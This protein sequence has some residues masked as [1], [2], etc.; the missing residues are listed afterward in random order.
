MASEALLTITEDEKAHFRQLS[1]EK[2]ELDMQSWETWKAEAKEEGRQE[3]I[4]EGIEKGI[5]QGIQ[6][7]EQKIIDMLKSGKS[8]EEILKEYEK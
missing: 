4:E 1:K 5:Q 7:G 6:K 3:G 2:Y 8:P